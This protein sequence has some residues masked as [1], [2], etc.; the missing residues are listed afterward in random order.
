[1]V[2]KTIWFYC[3]KDNELKLK[4]CYFAFEV[5]VYYGPIRARK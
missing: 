4:C 5:T 2:I 1:M 3:P